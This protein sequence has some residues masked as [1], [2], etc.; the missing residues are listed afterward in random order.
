V[1]IW[2]PASGT[3]RHTLTGHTGKVQTLVVAPDGSWLA[4]ADNAG[5]LRIWDPA[6]GVPLTSLRV[7][8]YLS[9]LA[10]VSTTIVAAGRHVPYSLALCHDVQ[11]G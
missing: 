6:R 10:L 9:H 8:G 11:S 3:A 4:T 7:A 2:D 5:E 1:R